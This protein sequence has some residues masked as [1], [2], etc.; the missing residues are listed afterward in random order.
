MLH[1]QHTR[2]LCIMKKTMKGKWIGQYWFSGNVPESLKNKETEFELII[3]SYLN[4]KISGTISD[5]METGGTA[6]TGTIS[7]NVKHN[8]V[9]FIKRMP[10]KTSVFQDG[11]RI[12]ENKPHRPIYYKGIIDIETNTVKGTWKFKLGIGFI[13][14]RLVIYSGTKGEWKM[15][16]T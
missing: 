16:K 7:G 9:K 3:D 12:E 15:K 10:I 14:G 11:T 1:V 8:K 2:L 5:N 6:G 4:S 13:N